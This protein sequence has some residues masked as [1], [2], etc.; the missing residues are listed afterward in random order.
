MIGLYRLHASEVNQEFLERRNKDVLIEVFEPDI[1]KLNIFGVESS[2][3]LKAM[4]VYWTLVSRGKYK[5]YYVREGDSVIH[6]SYCIP[7]CYKF[8]FMKETDLHVGPCVTDEG[9]RG[10]GIFPTVV[11]KIMA[12]HPDTVFYM[13]INDDNTA[14]IRGASKVGFKKVH[15]LEYQS[16]LKKFR[17]LKDPP[18]NRSKHVFHN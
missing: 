4:N 14:S 10:Q 5:I 16:I 15:R 17:I 8:P 9:S 7:K 2:L 6:T 11:S 12:D 13:V 18:S 3:K 1:S